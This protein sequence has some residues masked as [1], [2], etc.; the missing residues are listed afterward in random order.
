MSSNKVSSG[1][2]AQLPD[3]A[4]KASPGNCSKQES[5][6]EEEDDRI[7]REISPQRQRKWKEELDQELAR[8]RGI[9]DLIF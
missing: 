8:E 1:T 6:S 4:N 2:T 5:R 9:S 3:L 7:L